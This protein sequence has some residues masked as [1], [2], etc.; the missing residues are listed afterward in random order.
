LVRGY[1]ELCGKHHKNLDIAKEVGI[2]LGA[3]I[4]CPLGTSGSMRI[5]AF[6]LWSQVCQNET[7]PVLHWHSL[8]GDQ[9]SK[10]APSG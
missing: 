6:K 9:A 8:H 10:G 3:E 2:G 1:I 5:A 7:F 4:D